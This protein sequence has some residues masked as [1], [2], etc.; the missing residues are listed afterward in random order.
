MT[1]PGA[2]RRTRWRARSMAVAL[3]ASFATGC[4]DD[5][6]EGGDGVAG[7]GGVAG[8]APTPSPSTTSSTS[9]ASSGAGGDR[10]DGGGGGGAGAAE[11]GGGDAPVVFD[12]EELALIATLAP[13]ALPL[14]PDDPTNAWA[15]DPAAAELGQAFFFDPLFSGKLLDGDNDGS[16]HT[17]GVAGETGKV[18]CAGCHVPEAGFLDDRSLGQ[19]ISLAAGWVLRRTPSLLDVAQSKLLGW[20]GRR[21][22][23][24]NQAFQP[25]ESRDEMNSSRLYVAEQVFSRYRDEYEAIFGTLPPL[26][27]EARFPPLAAEDNG[28]RPSLG[29]EPPECHGMPGDGA[30][31]DGM[32]AADQEAVTRVVVNVGK[33]L[34]AYQRLLGCGPGRFDAWA[35]G[36]ETALS[37]AEQRGLRV[38]LG[39]GGCIACHAGPHLSDQAFHNIGLVPTIVAVAFIDRDDRG[40]GAD[41]PAA[42]ADPL[43]SRGIFSDGDDDRLPASVGPEMEGA[44]RTPTLRCVSRRPS[45]FHTGQVGTLEDVVAHFDDG[46]MP[47][48]YPGVSEIAPLGLGDAERDDL[49][50]FL[51][52]LDGPGPAAH[53]L[54]SP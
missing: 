6:R 26:D 28:C 32:S 51:R 21:D 25:I 15:D 39:D 48:G 14:P 22:A 31:Y 2:S 41:L 8:G 23:F 46:G 17:L 12:A 52:A 43:N 53:L 35:H 33:A 18:A 19:Q 42:M 37:A 44:F 29:D 54:A 50:A 5:E 38:F 34:G 45:F 9:D 20:G 13:A 1:G 16:E 4:G 7:G 30:E 11:G 27:D 3:F 49:V 10:G 24:H 36:D 40:A 47:G